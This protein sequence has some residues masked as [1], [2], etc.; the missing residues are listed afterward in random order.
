MYI[1]REVAVVE[2]VHKIATPRSTSAA[3]RLYL[4]RLRCTSINGLPDTIPVL[5]SCTV[6]HITRWAPGLVRWA[7]RSLGGC[8]GPGGLSVTDAPRCN[9]P[10]HPR[11]TS[12]ITF[13]T[14]LHTPFTN[15]HNVW[16]PPLTHRI[17]GFVW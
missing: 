12:Y 9:G 7:R 4:N 6:T 1:Y 2:V 8:R 10:P 16:R 11:S 15:R 5:C 13:H 14:P 17:N 3:A